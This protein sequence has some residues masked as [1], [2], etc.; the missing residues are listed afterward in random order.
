MSAGLLYRTLP[1]L[2]PLLGVPRAVVARLAAHRRALES[3]RSGTIE[4]DRIADGGAGI[5][6]VLLPHGP[7]PRFR[8]C[9]HGCGGCAASRR[10]R[11]SRTES[12]TTGHGE[13]I[14]LPGTTGC[15]DEQIL[16]LSVMTH[17][18]DEKLP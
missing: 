10:W 14:N 4:S 15:D 18:D 6:R 16:I 11:S 2:G 7:P 1:V 13:F 8:R 3:G 9:T 5:G 12:F 17:P